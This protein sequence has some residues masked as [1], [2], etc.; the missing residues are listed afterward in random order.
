MWLCNHVYFVSHRM[1]YYKQLYVILHHI[2]LFIS[3]IVKCIHHF[4]FLF[5]SIF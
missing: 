2:I 3:F 4:L 5:L 1:Y